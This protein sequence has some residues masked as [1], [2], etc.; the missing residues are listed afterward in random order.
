MHWYLHSYPRWPTDTVR[1]FAQRVDA[2]F[3]AWG[4]ALYQATLA[5][6]GMAAL[7][8]EWREATDPCQRRLTLRAADEPPA[9]RPARP[10]L[11]IPGRCHRLSVPGQATGPVP[12]SADRRG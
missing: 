10:A 12:A 11:G 4:Q 7:T 8:A 3:E 1:Q 6:P 9:S 2:L 5:P